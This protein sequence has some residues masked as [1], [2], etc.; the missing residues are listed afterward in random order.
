MKRKVLSFNPDFNED[1]WPLNT[2][3]DVKNEVLFGFPNINEWD[4]TPVGDILI[5]RTDQRDITPEQAELLVAFHRFEVHPGIAPIGETFMHMEGKE[6]EDF[7][8]ETVKACTNKINFT[9]FF[10][11]FLKDKVD[12]GEEAWARVTSPFDVSST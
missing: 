2:I 4:L 5:V 10:K 7:R 8:L 9:K 6:L 12:K 11:K 1:A 3:A